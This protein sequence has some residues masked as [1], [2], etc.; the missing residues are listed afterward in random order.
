KNCVG[1]QPRRGGKPTAQGNALGCWPARTTCKWIFA[2]SLRQSSARRPRLAGK[3]WARPS[4][5]SSP[6]VDPTGICRTSCLMAIATQICPRL[7][8]A[9][10]T[11]PWSY[12]QGLVGWGL[13]AASA[14]GSAALA[15]VPLPR[16]DELVRD[17]LACLPHG[18]RR[19]ADAAPPV[20][21]G[22]TGSGP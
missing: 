3:P 20:R 4:N 13:G 17:Q 9:L 5:L 16:R 14:P 10:Q 8:R 21:A 6:F 2:Q 18:T 22:V 12:G 1:F 11:P 15:Q 19:F 7:V